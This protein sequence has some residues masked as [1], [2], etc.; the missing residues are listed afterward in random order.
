[1]Q[2]AGNHKYNARSNY[3]KWLHQPFPIPLP[4]P[5][6]IAVAQLEKE[7]SLKEKQREKESSEAKQATEE[8]QR[9]LQGHLE[10][11]VLNTLPEM[12]I[13]L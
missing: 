2:E 12:G 9:V 1:M 8:H 7:C 6:P 13:G 3:I 4:P 11:K 10:K 5:P